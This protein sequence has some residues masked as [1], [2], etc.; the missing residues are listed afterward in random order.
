MKK[1]KLIFL[2]IGWL[3]VI[4]AV[5]WYLLDNV[6]CSRIQRRCTMYDLS[7]IDNEQDIE[8]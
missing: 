8:F 2:I 7:A 1:V 3:F 4:F 6:Y 5:A